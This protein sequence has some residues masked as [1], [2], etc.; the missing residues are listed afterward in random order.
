MRI[1]IV[2]AV[3]G[4]MSAAARARRLL[5]DAEIIVLDKGDYASFANCG[6]PYYLSGEIA[7]K[8]A[9]LVQT[10]ESLKAALN[11]DVRLNHEVVTISPE[12]QQV[13]V[14]T[15]A[16]IQKIAYDHLI[17][18]PGAQAFRP[19]VPGLESKRVHTLRTIND[20]LA[21]AETVNDSAKQAVVLGSGFI[22]LEAAEAL[23]HKGLE[24]TVVELA[25]QILTP[26]EPELAQLIKT[27]LNELGVK[28]LTSVAA[29]A[30][31]DQGDKDL[32]QLSDGTSLAADLIILSV[33]VSPATYAFSES[34]LLLERGAIVTNQHGQT[35]LPNVW[36]IGDAV[37][38]EDAVTG[39]A[40]PIALAGPANRG[41]RIIADNIAISEQL[42]AGEQ[43]EFQTLPKL[44]GTAI[45]RVGS[46]TAAVT[47][48]NSAALARAGIAFRTVHLHP[49][50]HAGYFPGAKQMQLVAHFDEQTGKILG[51]GIVGADGVDKRIDILATAIKA[52][53]DYR[54]LIELDLA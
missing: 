22:G 46:L 17:L 2:G 39:A 32:I 12:E 3:A 51:A 6:L 50:Q 45:I 44:L 30:I 36:A 19:D 34:G 48:A 28:T 35:N 29:V 52:G 13:T 9:L 7:E 54:D 15:E 21:I 14:Q 10:P 16:G 8:S 24:V 41:G 38:S 37:M 25:Q 11:L 18:S 26:L 49:K 33:G 43:V 5:E 31:T 23:A 42:A 40:R 53:M 27:E 47:G 1:V 20:V 4:G